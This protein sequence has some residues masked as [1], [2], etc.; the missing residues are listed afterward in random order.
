[1]QFCS[2]FTD[3]SL[4]VLN[5]AV[6]LLLHA[7]NCTYFIPFHGFWVLSY[8][9]YVCQFCGSEQ[10]KCCLLDKFENCSES[11]TQVLGGIL[12]PLYSLQNCLIIPIYQF[13]Q[14]DSLLFGESVQ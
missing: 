7:C 4:E 11:S 2:S 10:L 6:A 13:S 12:K 3:I 14:F 8:F 9:P 1:M 5:S